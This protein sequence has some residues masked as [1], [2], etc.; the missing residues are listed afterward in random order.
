MPP[1]GADN[2]DKWGA[3]PTQ[4][5]N[6]LDAYDEDESTLYELRNRTSIDE[7]APLAGG[8]AG[9]NEISFLIGLNKMQQVDGSD[10]TVCSTSVYSSICA[11]YVFSIHPSFDNIPFNVIRNNFS[12]E[13]RKRACHY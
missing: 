1:A 9:G 10:V 2:V 12:N 5:M 8:S 6:V 3:G 7:G 11:H 4:S 13:L